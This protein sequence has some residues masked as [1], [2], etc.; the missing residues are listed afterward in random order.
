M[1]T[2]MYAHTFFQGGSLTATDASGYSPLV[3]AAACGHVD[4]TRQLLE[5]NNRGAPSSKDDKSS[6][7]SQ[8]KRD[9]SL[10]QGSPLVQ[11]DSDGTKPSLPDNEKD[12]PYLTADGPLTPLHAAATVGAVEVCQLLTQ[13]S[14]SVRTDYIVDI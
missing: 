4:A 3:W 2:C 5:L 9:G 6:P 10:R 8:Y 14:H 11:E 12:A 13:H 1:I 7:S